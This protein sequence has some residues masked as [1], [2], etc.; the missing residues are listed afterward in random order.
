[1]KKV[2]WPDVHCAARQVYSCWRSRF[3]SHGNLVGG[4]LSVVSG[5]LKNKDQAPD[6]NSGQ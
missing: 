2:E 3:Y 4:Q 6:E 5:Q 1:M